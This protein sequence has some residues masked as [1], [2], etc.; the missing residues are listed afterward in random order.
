MFAQATDA[1][2]RVAASRASFRL[3]GLRSAW[4]RAQ[5][6]RL[7]CTTRQQRW[8]TH[9]VLKQYLRSAGTLVTMK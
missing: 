1:D 2:A 9:R 4:L 7:V 6:T 5:A 8:E 3:L